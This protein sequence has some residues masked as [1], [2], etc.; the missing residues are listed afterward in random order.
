MPAA[1]TFDGGIVWGSGEICR[2]WWRCRTSYAFS[3]VA[4]DDCHMLEPQV[5]AAGGNRNWPA[6]WRRDVLRQLDDLLAEPQMNNPHVGA[7]HALQMVVGSPFT[8][9]RHLLE[10]QDI[11]IERHGSIHVGDGEPDHRDLA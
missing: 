5:V 6:A 11:G 9:I 7:E 10:R 8:W 2:T 4:D 3:H 1:G